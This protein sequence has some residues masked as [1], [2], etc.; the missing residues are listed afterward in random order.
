ML[1]VPAPLSYLT[2]WVKKAVMS[3]RKDQSI[4]F[5][6]AYKRRCMVV[7]KAANYHARVT[8]RL[9]DSNKP[10]R[11]DPINGY[12]TKA[13]EYLDWHHISPYSKQHGLCDRNWTQMKPQCP[14][15][16]PLCLHASQDSTLNNRSN[17]FSYSYLSPLPSSKVKHCIANTIIN[18][19]HM[20]VVW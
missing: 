17:H 9:S 11:W 2:I 6:L 15:M 14:V 18:T 16:W 1:K 12:K 5:L 8:L 20:H 7:L 10:L 3:L 13:V 4:T 19:S